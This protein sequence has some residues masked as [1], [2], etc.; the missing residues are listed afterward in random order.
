VAG[1][2]L[3]TTIVINIAEKTDPHFSKSKQY[4]L[5]NQPVTFPYY[6]LREL[7]AGHVQLLCRLHNILRGSNNVGEAFLAISRMHPLE[8]RKKHS[9]FQALGEALSDLCQRSPK[10]TLEEVTPAL[11]RA[12]AL[13]IA[14]VWSSACRPT[15][16]EVTQPLS[17]FNHGD[18]GYGIMG[19]LRGPNG[20]FNCRSH[21]SNRCAAA[22]YIY[23]D[24]VALTNLIAALRPKKLT[25]GQASKNENIQ[26]RKVLKD[27][28][29]DGPS[30]FNKQKCRALGDAYFATMCP[31][32][33]V[34]VTT[35][36][37]DFEPL[38]AA[39]NKSFSVP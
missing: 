16:M 36:A 33:S 5:A 3:D 31:P 35:N 29:T 7:L 18:V 30:K 19:E 17:C 20:S 15:A 27:L 9:S 8:G 25:P 4:L 34:V 12:L 21:A 22:A 14:R 26:R 6:A 28:Q 11:T 1:S 32:G 39:L 24:Q 38:C 13:R 10:G 23:G 2:F 37:S